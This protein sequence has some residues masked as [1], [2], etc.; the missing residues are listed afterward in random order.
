LSTS[1]NELLENVTEPED[2]EVA[3]RQVLGPLSGHWQA[4]T[5]TPDTGLPVGFTVVK[6]KT[7]EDA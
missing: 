6:V 2:V 1:G 3:V 5:I 7:F 4:S